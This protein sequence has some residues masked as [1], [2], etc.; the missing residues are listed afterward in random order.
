M[1]K[2]YCFGNPDIKEDKIALELADILSREKSLK[3][4]VEFVKCTSP[5][6]LLNI[7]EKDLIIIDAVKGLKDVKII[8]DINE[9]RETKTT[10]MHDFDLGSFLKLMKEAGALRNITI[11]GVPYTADKRKIRKI[12]PSLYLALRN[13]QSS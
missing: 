10:T 5:D 4:K 1:K 8:K 9:I 13:A 7:N 3:N 11:I 6:F 12:M 2:V